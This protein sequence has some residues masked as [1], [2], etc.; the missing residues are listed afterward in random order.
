MLGKSDYRQGDHTAD[1]KRRGKSRAST[2]AKAWQKKHYAK[3][4][5]TRKKLE[6]AH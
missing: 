3:G 1:Y 2:L 6:E 4:A 5:E